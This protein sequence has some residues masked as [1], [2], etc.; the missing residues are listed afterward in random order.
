MCENKELDDKFSK[1]VRPSISLL[2]DGLHTQE[3]NVPNDLKT[4][5]KLLDESKK[6]DNIDE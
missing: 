3:E 5:K 1:H 2:R 4:L 6:E